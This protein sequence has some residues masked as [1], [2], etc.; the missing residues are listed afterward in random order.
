M[1]AQFLLLGLFLVSYSVAF[2]A[3][4]SPLQDFCVAD[5]S[6]PG[7]YIYILF[8][9]IYIVLGFLKIYIALVHTFYFCFNVTVLVNG[10]ACKNPIHVKAN[11]FFTSGLHLVGNT[12][13]PTRSRVNPITVVQLS[14]LNSLGISMVRIDYAPLGMNPPHTHPQASEILAVL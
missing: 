7:I 11:D 6:S 2:A 1:A 4:H 14:G 5:P 13:N 3:D 10:F 12:L 8:F 9:H